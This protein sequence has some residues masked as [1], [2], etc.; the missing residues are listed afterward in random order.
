MYSFIVK[1]FV[2]VILTLFLSV[3]AGAQSGAVPSDRCR[4]SLKVD[5]FL[6]LDDAAAAKRAFETFRNALLS[7]NREQVIELMNFPADLVVNGYPLKIGTAREFLGKYDRVFTGYVIGS[8]RNQKPD[9]LLGGWDG[10]SLS[11]GAV[12]FMRTE[13]GEFRISDVRPKRVRP[14]NFIADFLE[15]RLSCPPV[16]V[17]GRIV[18]YNWVSHSFPGFENIYVDHLIVD[19]TSVINGTVPQERIRVDFWG[20]SH[21]PEYNL[22]PKAFEPGSVWRMYLRPADAPPANDEVC[23]R[24]VQESISSVDEAGRELKKESA[25]KVLA[26][27]STPTYSGLPCFEVHKQFFTTSW[28]FKSDRRAFEQVARVALVALH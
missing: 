9:E 19:V 21:L 23:G 15:H 16:V 17:D 13:S 22:T 8:V 1:H 11:N 7:G 26:G 14:P 18:A 25:I 5:E 20:V 24:E 6:L 28:S 2:I 10:V 27:G 3:A 4:K 12:R